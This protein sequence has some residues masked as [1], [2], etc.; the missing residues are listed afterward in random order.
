MWQKNNDGRNAK[1]IAFLLFIGLIFADA[2][3]AFYLL[4]DSISSNIAEQ[5]NV[6]S[7]A[8]VVFL[9]L[10]AKLPEQPTPTP[11]P[12]T[13]TPEPKT[14]TVQAGD[15]LFSIALDNNVSL[16]ELA[17]VNQIEDVDLILVGQV[18]IIPEPTPVPETPAEAS[19][20]YP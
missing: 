18:L 20:P 6:V 11:E 17:R 10:V 9:P 7:Q 16:E 8:R 15:T 19:T 3:V 1:T 5:A 14:Y 12:A 4:R 13:P 2:L